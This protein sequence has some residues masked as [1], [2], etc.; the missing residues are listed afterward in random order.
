MHDQLTL[1][2]LVRSRIQPVSQSA[3]HRINLAVNHSFGRTFQQSVFLVVTAVVNSLPG[4]S[5]S[6]GS[7][8]PRVLVELNR[9]LPEL[10]LFNIGGEEDHF[11]SPRRPQGP[12][13]LSYNMLLFF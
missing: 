2:S 7:C 8:L 6:V 3:G 11:A 4:Q 10:H 1:F 9:A 12:E 13:I 5:A